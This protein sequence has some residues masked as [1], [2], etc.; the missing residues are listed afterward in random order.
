MCFSATAS[1]V[2][3]AVLTTSGAACLSKTK[4][5][6][7][8][9][10]AS[11]PFIF[12]IQ[13]FFEGLVWLY[14]A[15]GWLTQVFAYIFL[16]FAFLW[17]PV[18]VPLTVWAHEQDASRKCILRYLI[19]FGILGALY[20]LFVLLTQLLVV[21]IM[22]YSIRYD[23]DTW[24]YVPGITLYVIVTIGSVLLSTT[25]FIQWFGILTLF[26]AWIAWGFYERTFTSVWCFFAA[27]LSLVLVW[28][29]FSRGHKNHL[30]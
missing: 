30:S 14:P 21:Q 24:F 7:D 4:K 9:L 20:L 25:R 29:F 1:F 13:Q 12:G 15:N 28:Y 22:D 10:L 16:F 6:E 17:W 26:S 23:I 27:M 3:S 19:G 8:V 18:Y 5:K 2:A 11:I